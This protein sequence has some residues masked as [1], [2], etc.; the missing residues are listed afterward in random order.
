[1]EVAIMLFDGFDDLDAVGPLEVFGHAGSRLAVE[2]GLYTPEPRERVTS[3]HGLVLR[4]DGVLPV[5][6]ADVDLVVVPGGGWNAG[7]TTGVRAQV[8]SGCLPEALAR[9]HK[10]GVTVASVCT[11]AMLLAAAGLTSGRPAVTHHGATN[12]LRASGAEVVEARVVD[13]GDVLTAA[14]VTAGIDLA[15]HVLER[16]YGSETATRVAETIAH[17]RR[18][19]VV[20][21]EE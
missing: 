5:S 18:G 16:K 2:A 15:L 1:M 6:P 19:P 11:G 20:T 8:D 13:T 3:A 10:R 4:P 9:L 14:G 12:E 7:A 21:T 17:E